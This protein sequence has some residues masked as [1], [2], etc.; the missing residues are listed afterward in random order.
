M[1]IVIFSSNSKA[2]NAGLKDLILKRKSDIV[3]LIIVNQLKGGLYRQFLAFLRYAKRTSLLFLVYK[4]YES[5]GSSEVTDTAKKLGIPVI[6]AADVNDKE[7]LENLKVLKPDLT[8]CLF[9]NQMLKKQVISIPKLGTLNAHG[10]LLPKYRGAAQ[11]FWYLF[12]GDKKGGVTV[13]YMDEG[14]DTGDIVLQKEFDIKKDDSMLSLHIKIGKTATGLYDKVIELFKNK[15]AKRIPQA[16][17]NTSYLT[18]PTRNE[19]GQFRKKG[20]KIFRL[21]LL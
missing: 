8:L 5:M 2:A 20:H 17:A 15:K 6:K 7:F 4:L 18:L 19:M 12:N 16:K 13:H 3:A 11:Y 10:S 9:A 1:R 14:L 21:S